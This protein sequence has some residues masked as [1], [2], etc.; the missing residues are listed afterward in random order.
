MGSIRRN[1]REQVNKKKGVYAPLPEDKIDRPIGSYPKN[2]PWT[3][4]GADVDIKKKKKSNFNSKITN[5]KQSKKSKSQLKKD[6]VKREIKPIPDKFVQKIPGAQKSSSK[7][8]T[9]TAAHFEYQERDETQ[10]IPT[11]DDFLEFILTDL[12]GQGFSSHWVPYWKLV[13]TTLRIFGK[14]HNW[15]AKFPFLGIMQF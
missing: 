5:K 12:T 11:L 7:N 15:I 13:L 3:G 10:I 8:L 6:R 2:N 9:T 4:N 1:R 14:R